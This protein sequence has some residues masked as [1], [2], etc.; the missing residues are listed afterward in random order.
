M[1]FGQWRKLSAEELMLL[2]CGVGEDS[3]ES[4]G[5]QGDPTSPYYRRSVLGIHWRTDAEA[6]TPILWPPHAKN[7]LIGKDPNAGKD[8]R[9]E[10]EGT[11]R[12][13]D[14]WM[15]S[16][17]WWTWVWVDSRSWWWTRRPSVLRF[18][19]S[20]RVGH[21]W[22]IELNWTWLLNT[23]SWWIFSVM[24]K[25]RYKD[26]HILTSNPIIYFPG[27]FPFMHL[28]GQP[29]HFLLSINILTLN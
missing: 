26:L 14:G 4:L 12:V 7:W 23:S 10:E 11:T 1:R 19:G 20:Q 6:A 28:N 29:N 8:W 22:A 21:H 5:L 24:I 25:M 17:T 16:P 2:N 18:M 27:I 3:W 13:W 9:W 15:A